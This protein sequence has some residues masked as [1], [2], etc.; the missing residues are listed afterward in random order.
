MGRF[1]NGL[2]YRF[3]RGRGCMASDLS[4]DTVWPAVARRLGEW[5]AVLPVAAKNGRAN[6]RERG[7]DTSLAAP[8]GA[9]ANRAGPCV[10]STPGGPTKPS[11][12]LWTVMQRWVSVLPE[13]TAAEAKRKSLLQTECRR[14]VDDLA[15]LSSFGTNGVGPPPQKAVGRG[16][17]A[18]GSSS[19]SAIATFSRGT[20]SLKRPKGVPRPR[21]SRL[22]IL[23]TTSKTRNRREPLRGWERHHANNAR[24]SRYAAPSPAPF[25]I[26]N[27]FAEWAG[28]DCDY[29]AMPSRSQRR[30]FLS[31]YLRSY[32]QHASSVVADRCVR[33][34]KDGKDALLDR[35][36]QEVD[37]FRGVPGFF[38][39]VWQSY[40]LASLRVRDPGADIEPAGAGAY[41]GSSK[42]RSHRSTLTM[43]PT[44][45]SVC[46]STGTGGPRRAAQE[47]HE[48][49]N[50]R[51]E[52]GDGHVKT[53][54]G[55]ARSRPL[56]RC[57]NI[58]IQMPDRWVYLDRAY[59]TCPIRG[60]CH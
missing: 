52:S 43:E 38:W 27:H 32:R 29:R 10:H 55:W 37:R 36:F 24:P 25:D 42:P 2:L 53:D 7:E 34:G 60:Q 51:C 35:L 41:G 16:V 4:R 58:I 54:N 57:C 20:L 17:H 12:T 31:E 28:L 26:A 56:G 6:L 49:K 19:F 39:C 1:E 46:A 40:L 14:L 48:E 9:T 22:F 13:D 33:D 30:A 59:Q 5:H 11:A 50:S 15:E 21:T 44:P 8:N 45:S 47:P 18:D 3:I 23:L